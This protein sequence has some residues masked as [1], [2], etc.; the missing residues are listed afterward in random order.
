MRKLEINLQEETFKFK[1]FFSKILIQ[2]KGVNLHVKSE[3][4]ITTYGLERDHP[5]ASERNKIDE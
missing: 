3:I 5:P 4:D 2:I 1:V